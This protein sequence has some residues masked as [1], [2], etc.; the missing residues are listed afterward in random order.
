MR[1]QEKH[2]Q[3]E[4]MA[5]RSEVVHCYGQLASS[6]SQMVELAR[7]KEWGQLPALEAQCSAVVERL[8][9][10][11][12][13]ESLDSTQ[14]EQALRLIDRIRIDQ[15]EVSGLIKP[16]LDELIGRM[17]YLHQQRNLGKAYGPPH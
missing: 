9:V 16:Q 10:I 14:L 3:Q 8:R 11:E 5:A 1:D 2:K 12:P 13:L 6:I 17:G 4:K 7:A 15:A